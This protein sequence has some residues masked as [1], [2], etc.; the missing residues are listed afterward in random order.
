MLQ[1][2]GLPFANAFCTDAVVVKEDVIL[3]LRAVS[4]PER[5]KR[6][7]DVQAGSTRRIFHL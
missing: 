2:A 7:D 6:F 1:L 3:P 4:K 5:L